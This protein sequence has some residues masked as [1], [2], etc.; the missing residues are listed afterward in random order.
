MAETAPETTEK[1]SA[2]ALGIGGRLK[3]AFS[4]FV[5][6]FGILQVIIY[7]IIV[8]PLMHE[9]VE[10]RTTAIVT[11]F[12]EQAKTPLLVQDH[13]KVVGLAKSTA[14]LDG[15]AYVYLV[16]KENRPMAHIFHKDGGF[17]TDFSERVKNEGVPSELLG[18]NRLT[19]GQA[20]SVK[21]FAVG[22]KEVTEVAVPVTDT[23]IEAHVG[24]FTDEINAALSRSAIP[25]Y[26]LIAVTMLIGF[27]FAT[28]IGARISKPIRQLTDQANKISMGDLETDIK[29]ESP[30]GEIAD[31]ASAFG[32]MQ[33]S[34]RFAAEMMK[35]K[36]A[37][38]AEGEG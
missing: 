24:L 4:G 37:R 17:D 8:P 36:K 15:V 23:A 31:L 5:L 22:G 14:N 16:N 21:Q 11:M 9:Q 13:I 32:R 12:S 35:K 34:V 2:T 3:L 18:M 38:R 6:V 26:I 10:G 20:K 29:V 30:C 33:T 27:G 19:E 7:N 1:K 25:F 28:F